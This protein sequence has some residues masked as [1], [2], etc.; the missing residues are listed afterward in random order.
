[1]SSQF[2]VATAEEVSFEFTA[3]KLAMLGVFETLGVDVPKAAN[4][5]AHTSPFPLPRN[6]EGGIPEAYADRLY[7]RSWVVEAEMM[8]AVGQFLSVE[9]DRL[10]ANNERIEAERIEAA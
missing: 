4:D 10:K 3:T 8:G 7:F 1:M 5:W 6:A 2:T 9:A